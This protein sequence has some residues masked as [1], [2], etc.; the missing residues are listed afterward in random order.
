MVFEGLDPSIHLRRH[1]TMSLDVVVRRAIDAAA[2]QADSDAAWSDVL[3]GFCHLTG[4]D[5]GSFVMLDGSWQLLDLRLTGTSEKAQADY[6]QHFHAHDIMNPLA[7]DCAAG[8]WLNSAEHY[9]A[10]RLSGNPF[11]ADFMCTHRIQQMMAYMVEV[12]PTRRAGICVQRSSVDDHIRT[13]TSS[14]AMRELA[15]AATEGLAHQRA[16]AAHAMHSVDV[17]FQAFGEIVFLVSA[18]CALVH[19]PPKARAWF[20]TAGAL[21]ERGGRLHHATPPVE[22]CWRLAVLQASRSSTPQALGLPNTSGFAHRLE[23]AGA[24][25]AMSHTRETLVLVRVSTRG[26]ASPSSA[27]VLRAAFGLTSAEAAVLS[28]L[29]AGASAK[30]LAAQ[31]GVALSTVRTQIAALMEKVGCSRQVDL[32]RKASDLV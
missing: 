21:I 16:R 3:A 8:T 32:V 12:S 11:Y 7:R 13:V 5:S 23:L 4:G 31:R 28:A 27:G 26:P 18:S 17:A 15:R 20:G 19:A 24:D 9:S 10:S 1:R 22:S 14:T 25:P 2:H 6:V 29:I 30:Q